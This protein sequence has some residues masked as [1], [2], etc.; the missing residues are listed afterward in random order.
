MNGLTSKRKDKAPC[1]LL[2]SRRTVLLHYCI[3][4][5][6]E[7]QEAQE[8]MSPIEI[9]NASQGLKFW[10]LFGLCLLIS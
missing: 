6:D 3:Q 2:S 9:W 4:Y 10:L 7:Q 5:T 1:I 8:F